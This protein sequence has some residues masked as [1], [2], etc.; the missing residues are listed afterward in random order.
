MITQ[1]ASH[2]MHPWD[3]CDLLHT[4]QAFKW[5][6]FQRETITGLTHINPF[7]L[8]ACKETTSFISEPKVYFFDVFDVSKAKNILISPE[9][10]HH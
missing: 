7:K 10:S 8:R 9:S 1:S 4:D 3:E 5:L 2:F 6:Y